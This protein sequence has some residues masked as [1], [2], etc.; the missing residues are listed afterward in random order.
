MWLWLADSS[1]SKAWC[2]WTLPW[3]LD[4]SCGGGQEQRLE[5][6]GRHAAAGTGSVSDLVGLVRGRFHFL[7]DPALELV[8]V[9]EELLQFG[10][11]LQGGVAGLSVLMQGIAATQQLQTCGRYFVRKMSRQWF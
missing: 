10:G 7:V 9:P 4:G 5:D 1:A 8:R 2:F 11:V 3:R 6:S